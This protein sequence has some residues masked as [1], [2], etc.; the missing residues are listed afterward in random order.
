LPDKPS[1]AV[2]AFDNMSGDPHQEYF[3]E[4]F[5]KIRTSPLD[6][7][8]DGYAGDPSDGEVHCGFMLGP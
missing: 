1:I 5:G 3:S 8:V 6:A 2:L 7:V 4:F